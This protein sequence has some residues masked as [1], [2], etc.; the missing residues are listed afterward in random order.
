MSTA[1]L[2]KRKS[3]TRICTGWVQKTRYAKMLEIP[4]F[5]RFFNIF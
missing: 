3:G 2:S 1:L 4:D 5:M